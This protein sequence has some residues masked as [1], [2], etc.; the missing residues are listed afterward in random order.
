MHS[1]TK[2]KFLAACVSNVWYVAELYDIE[3]VNNHIMEKN[4]CRHS[5]QMAKLPK[6]LTFLTHIS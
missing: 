2:D 5:I 3:L 1:R 6:I 4:L